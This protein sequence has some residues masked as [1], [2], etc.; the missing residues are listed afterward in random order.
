MAGKWGTVATYWWDHKYFNLISGWP[1]QCKLAEHQSWL[2]KSLENFWIPDSEDD[3]LIQPSLMGLFGEASGIDSKHWCCKFLTVS[4]PLQSGMSGWAKPG[5]QATCHGVRRRWYKISHASYCDT[6]T[7]I[8]A[9][10][11]GH[12]MVTMQRSLEW[13]LHGKTTTLLVRDP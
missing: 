7:M 10:E 3:T 9:K 4:S 13:G 1:F 2:E 6:V 11:K 12:W 8:S 5:V